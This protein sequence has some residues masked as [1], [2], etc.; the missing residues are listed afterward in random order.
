[1]RFGQYWHSRGPLGCGRGRLFDSAQDDSVKTDTTL[2]QREMERPRGFLMTPG[3]LGELGDS[4]W[5][6]CGVV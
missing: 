5:R 4:L 2:I 1:M 3:I 6:T